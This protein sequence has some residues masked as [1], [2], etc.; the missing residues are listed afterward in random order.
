MKK[1]L[2][3][4]YLNYLIIAF[5]SFISLGML[6]SFVSRVVNPPVS[7]EIDDNVFK[8]RAEEVI[9]VNVL[10]GCGVSGLAGR[11]ENY[12]RELGFDVV[13]IGNYDTMISE[14]II[15]DR[16]GDHA[17]AKKVAK[18]IGLAETRIITKIDSTLYLRA[19]IVLGHD[20]SA[21]KFIN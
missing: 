16:V 21:L 15:I 13:E 12:L 11:A 3:I 14:T 2:Q 1:Y 8:Y 18:A 20:H 10:N 7:A 6:S 19:S 5:L 17:S 9:Q 4:K